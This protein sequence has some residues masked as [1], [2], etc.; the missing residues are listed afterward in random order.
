MVKDKTLAAGF[1]AYILYLDPI[2]VCAS[3]RVTGRKANVCLSV[4][5]SVCLSVRTVC[6]SVFLSVGL[7]VYHMCMT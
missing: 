1:K 3:A 5:P 7:S 4:S 6:L 2:S